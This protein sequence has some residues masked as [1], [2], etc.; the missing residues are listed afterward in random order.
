MGLTV[1]IITVGT[2]VSLVLLVVLIHPVCV[3]LVCL[4]SDLLNCDWYVS[5][6]DS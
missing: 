4:Y 1:V 6:E 2:V 5:L 3:F